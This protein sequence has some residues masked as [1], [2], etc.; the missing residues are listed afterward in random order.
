MA[1]AST[2][3]SG[4]DQ[5]PTIK[6]MKNRRRTFKAQI[7]MLSKALE[8][9]QDSTKE[10]LKLRE[11]VERLRKQFDTFNEIQDELGLIENFEQ[12]E[13]EREAV[14]EQFDEAIATALT[15]LQEAERVT[16]Q[17]PSTEIRVANESP[18]P[19]TSSTA[20]GVHLPKIDLPKFDGRLEKWIAFKDAFQTM[21]HAHTG[22]SDIQKLH[23]L[24]L[25][26]SGKAESAIESFTISEDN[27][28]ATWDQ[29]IETYDNTRALVLRHSALLRDT[30]AMIDDTAESIRD[31]VNH[32]QSQI[33]SLHALG[34]SWEDIANDLLT[35][36]AISKMG[37]NTKRE[38]EQTLS[39]T[40]MPKI[41]DVFRHLRNASHRCRSEESPQTESNAPISN[42]YHAPSASTA[43]SRPALAKTSPTFARKSTRPNKPPSPR[44]GRRQTFV[45][46]SATSCKICNS[47]PHQVFQCQR[48]LDMTVKDRIQA[49]RKANL[50]FNCLQTDH[51]TRDC[52]GGKCRVCNGRH[53]TKLH[54]D[55]TTPGNAKK[56]HQDA[57]T[58]DNANKSRTGPST[59]R[60]QGTHLGPDT[61]TNG[62][63]AT[64]IVEVLDRDR[65]PV[66]CRTLVDTC[67]NANFI[68]EDLAD[69]LR[70]PSTRAS[71]A[72]QGLN[73][74]NTV[75]NKL[76]TTTIKSRCSNYQRQLTFFTIPQISDRTPDMPMDR[77]KIRIPPN[78]RLADPHFHQPGKVDMLIGTGPALSCLSIGQLDLS[79]QS[80]R[81]LILQKTQLGWII[82]GNVP[83]STTRAAHK[84]FIAN[85]EVSLQRFWEVEEGPCDQHFSIEERECEKH[86]VENV[87]RDDSGRYTVA[88]PFN[89][90]KNNLGESRSRAL[91]RLLSLE[92]KLERNPELKEQYTA[93]LNEY[94]ALG[95]MS[96]VEGFDAR[97]FYLP[98]H[99]VIKPSSATTKV[100]VVF[101]GSAKT[102]TGVSL[103]DALMIGPTIQ[104][105]LFS[106]LLR[107][108]TY[109]FV[110]TGD[111]EKMYRQFLVRPEDRAYQ[112]ILWRNKDGHVKTYELNVVT[113]GLSSAPFLAIRCIHQLADDERDAY[114]EA[115]TV[116]K[117]DLYVDDLLTG[118][119]TAQQAKRMQTQISNLLKTGGLNIRQWASNEPNILEGLSEEQIH[120]KILG[121][122]A[123]MKTLGV[124]WDARND[125]IRY[126]VEIPT[127]GKISKRSI[128]ST[129]AKIF[130][131]LGLLG[132]VT[133][134]AK[135]LM[136]RLRQLKISW[137]ESLPANLHTEWITY[138]AQLQE[139]NNMECN[140][141][142]IE[143]HGF[144]DSSERAY[145]ACIY[146]RTISEDGHIET[147]LLCA[148]SRVAP[149]KTITL[150][151][152][153]LCGAALL[154]SL[155]ASVRK[156][157]TRD[158]KE[159]FLW[160]DSTIVLNWIKKQPNT[161]KTFVANRVADIQRKTDTES[162]RHI[163]S[164]HNP[165]DL[166]S[167]GV[168]PA[169][170]HNNGFWFHG[171]DWLADHRA[172]WPESKVSLTDEVPELKRVTCLVS[173]TIWSEEILARYSCL[174]RLTPERRD[175]HP[176]FVPQEAYAGRRVLSPLPSTR[177]GTID[178]RGAARSQTTYHQA[179]ATHLIRTGHSGPRRRKITSEE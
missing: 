99:A 179:G 144:C 89:E 78:I 116:L 5:L 11:R 136:Q 146:V 66:H 148:K 23:Y 172:R 75:A 35:S 32:M 175:P 114:P 113:F 50:C 4:A 10:R 100:R 153:E 156:A 141:H 61:P 54:Q 19:S 177:R 132:P 37:P 44:S 74:A 119:D 92:R 120:P 45:A 59:S 8:T 96:Q 143:L 21:I 1:T 14:T 31:L 138:A 73:Q 79:D 147:H 123:V 58:P 111:I 106:L 115:A 77:S 40:S 121:D 30:P 76:V 53:N 26:L 176:I 49:A 46:T 94:L 9:Y 17:Q 88:L 112:R 149:L 103:N 68:T 80:G 164:E 139:L 104:D 155:Y 158:I 63:L 133:I 97:G 62:L 105:D 178:H 33:R 85:L 110:I 95:H 140:R 27:Y 72:I 159:T 65:Q 25:S 173:S 128:L 2:H 93:V 64:A 161:L 6:L 130:D 12:T 125:T 24:R 160:T 47:G 16:T 84:T 117:R 13:A 151:R 129:I 168:M 51:A 157:I 150:A 166:I 169:Q 70:L 39:D 87:R 152:L 42:E 7:T 145:G 91:N 122:A 29:L 18:S 98:H 170:F 171:P 101:D 83:V 20:I 137:D 167:R 86:F 15:L 28:R 82:G 81:D 174:K 90:K 55:A 135:I 34:R 118:A 126:T 57:A 71:V 127:N 108:R 38:W 124:S 3:E 163:K 41:S 48:F 131:P 142:H 52:N 162:W 36:I 107:F 22:L 109:A 60:Q 154:A 67:S 43:P 134:I 165:A 56:L 69:K 102:S